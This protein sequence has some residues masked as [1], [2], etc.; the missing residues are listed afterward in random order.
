MK[1]FW[2]TEFGKKDSEGDWYFFG[3]IRFDSP[4][5]ADEYFRGMIPLKG[6][7][8]YLEYCDP[9]TADVLAIKEGK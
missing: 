2:S 6:E 7:R 5:E 3:A 4:Q 8:A 1:Q 9:Y